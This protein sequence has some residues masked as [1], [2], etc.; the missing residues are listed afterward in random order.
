MPPPTKQKVE[1]PD[2]Y[3]KLGEIDGKL[4][5]LLIMQTKII[6][7]LIALAGATV[8]LKLMGS[9]PLLIVSSFINGFIFLFAIILAIH[10][11]QEIKGWQYILTFGVFGVVGNI[12][13]VI[14]PDVVSFRTCIFIIG[15]LALLIY[16]WQSDNWGYKG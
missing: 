14:A 10:R 7:A 9:P 8:G 11:R 6:Y 13:K 5:G 3:Y 1:L 4:D 12:H 16:V 15:N 2:L